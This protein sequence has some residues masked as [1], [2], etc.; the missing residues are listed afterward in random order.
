M[1]SNQRVCYTCGATYDYCPSCSHSSDKPHWML[2]W[3]TEECKDVYAAVSAYNFG[4][5]DAA[6]VKEVLDKYG[7]DSRKYSAPIQKQLQKIFSPSKVE[8]AK[9]VD[10]DSRKERE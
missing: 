5:A 9:S 7:A 6:D 2:L 10:I 8:K 3:D 4:Y 1:A